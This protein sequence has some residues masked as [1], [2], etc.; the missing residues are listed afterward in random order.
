MTGQ[1]QS[2]QTSIAGR[3]PNGKSSARED[4]FA[5]VSL[6][7]HWRTSPPR[8]IW[9]PRSVIPASPIRAP[10]WQNP[11]L[12]R[13]F[14]WGSLLGSSPACLRAPPQGSPPRSARR[15]QRTE[16]KV[17]SAC[18]I[19]NATAQPHA[20][21]GFRSSS[22]NLRRSKPSSNLLLKKRHL[23]TALGRPVDVAPIVLE[24]G[25]LPL[26]VLHYLVIAPGPS[27]IQQPVH[28]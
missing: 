22:R 8:T 18:A 10:V 14:A 19:P 23:H 4:G 5:S 28:Q 27:G 11:K 21:P 15:V 12:R 25:K 16:T 7:I 3:W 2:D 17:A 26:A 9:S 6:I 13:I 20:P 24:P 1:A